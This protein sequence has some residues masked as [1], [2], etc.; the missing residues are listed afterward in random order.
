[1]RRFLLPAAVG[2]IGIA[3]I[4]YGFTLGLAGSGTTSGV[5]AIRLL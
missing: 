5:A 1:M 2:I 3:A 4:F